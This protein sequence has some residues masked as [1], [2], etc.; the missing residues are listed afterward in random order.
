M[1]KLSC[2]IAYLEPELKEQLR[3]SPLGISG[4]IRA[5][6]R[7]LDDMLGAPTNTPVVDLDRTDWHYNE[8]D[9]KPHLLPDTPKLVVGWFEYAA[10]L[11]LA[12]GLIWAI[13]SVLL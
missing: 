1:S 6:L 12:G 10:G 5:R 9:P 13:L 4:E 3:L 2:T 7:M 11:L 8:N